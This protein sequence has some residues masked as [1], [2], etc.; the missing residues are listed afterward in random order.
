MSLRQ[1]LADDPG[2]AGR[3]ARAGS[4]PLPVRDVARLLPVGDG[5]RGVLPRA[6]MSAAG[7]VRP[8][9]GDA[10]LVVDVQNDFLPGGA[11][12][13]NAGNAVLAPLNDWIERFAK[14]ALPIFATRDWH[15]LNHC[16]FRAQGGPWPP[17]CIAGTAGADFP[18]RLKLP[19]DVQVIGKGTLPQD[20]AYSGF[21]GTDLDLRLRRQAIH[22]LFVGGLATDYCVL[23]TVLEGLRLK[24]R[25]VLLAEAIRALNARPGDEARAVSAMRDA[26][27][28]LVEG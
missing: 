20:D 11:L 22:R 16:S 7:E 24:Y 23:A 6:A 21:S 28:V 15:P 26:G 17:H 25:V 9:A 1:T 5:G 18:S 8:E 27:A 10:L 3:R 2:G 13:V 4:N 12:P 19:P 14:A